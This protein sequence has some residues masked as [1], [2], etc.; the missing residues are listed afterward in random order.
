[1]KKQIID[2]AIGFST[3]L[4]VLGIAGTILLAPVYPKPVVACNANSC[5]A[6]IAQHK[7]VSASTPTPAYVAAVQPEETPVP[8][9][10]QSVP[11]SVQQPEA[12]EPTP[13]PAFQPEPTAA[14][15]I[16]PLPTATIPQPQTQTPQSPEEKIDNTHEETQ[17]QQQKNVVEQTLK[18]VNTI[19]S[20]VTSLLK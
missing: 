15:P 18:P 6:Q 5:A 2:S 3:L 20:G 9:T 19:V 10:H 4:L 14:G 13:T 7:Q 1:M 8:E 12:S 16:Q 17:G 11:T